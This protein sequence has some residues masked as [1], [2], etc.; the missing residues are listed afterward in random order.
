MGGWDAPY[1]GRLRA[2]VRKSAS[3]GVQ[4]YHTGSAEGALRRVY[5][6]LY[7]DID[8]RGEC[9]DADKAWDP[10]TLDMIADV[11]RGHFGDPPASISPRSRGLR[12]LQRA[13]SWRFA[14]LRGQERGVSGL[15]LD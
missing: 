1:W 9:Y 6:I 13:A 2:A 14:T 4:T 10:S 8:Q 3:E 11:V 15:T 5:D 7:L 12:V